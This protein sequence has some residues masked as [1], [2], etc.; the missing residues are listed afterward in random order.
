MA[1]NYAKQA[2]RIN[3]VC[4]SATDTPGITKYHTEFSCQLRLTPN[5]SFLSK[6]LIGYGAGAEPYK[7]SDA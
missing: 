2:F 3:S 6:M 1:A 7:A 4:S 5:M